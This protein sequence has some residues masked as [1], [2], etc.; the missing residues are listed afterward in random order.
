MKMVNVYFG[1]FQRI[2]MILVLA[3]ILNGVKHR[4]I[5]LLFMLVI[6]VKKKKRMKMVV[7]RII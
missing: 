5:V 7:K 4:Q 2:I 1:N 3:F 6:Q